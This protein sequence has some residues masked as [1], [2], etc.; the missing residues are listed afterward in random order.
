[1]FVSTKTFIPTALRF[2]AT[3][4]ND[5]SFPVYRRRGPIESR[6]GPGLY[7][8]RNVRTKITVRVVTEFEFFSNSTIFV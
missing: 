7:S 3:V 2:P 1:V 4:G 6:F 8:W 5:I